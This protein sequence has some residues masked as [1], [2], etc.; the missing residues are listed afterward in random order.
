MASKDVFYCITSV[1]TGHTDIIFPV[2]DPGWMLGKLLWLQP[3][4]QS[5]SNSCSLTRFLRVSTAQPG[6]LRLK[7]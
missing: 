3:S 4:S 2:I 7:A 6:P 5:C 1:F